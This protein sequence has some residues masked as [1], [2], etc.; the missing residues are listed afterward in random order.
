MGTYVN[1][2]NSGFAEINDPDYVDK[3][4][5]IRLVNQTIGK[6]NKLTCISRPR[7]FG[8]SYAARMLT[9]YYDCSCDSHELFD[10]KEIAQD[11]NYEKYLNRYNVIYLEMTSFIS[12]ARR[13]GISLREVPNRI[14]AA[15]KKDLDS[16][17]SYERK[18]DSL[19]DSLIHIAEK[20][21]G[22]KFIFI[23]DE[24]DAMIREAKDDGVAQKRYLDL[25][26]EWFKN[27][28]F[29]PKA[30]AAA[31]MTGIL[32]IKKDGSQSAISEFKEYTMIR[33]GVF[34]PYIGFTEFEVL[35]LCNAHDIHFE[36]MKTWYDGYHFK[37]VSSI[38]NPNSIMEAIRNR[39]FDSYWVQTSAAESLLTYIDMNEDGLQEDVARLISG[40]EIE[41]RTEM[42]QNDFQ[43]FRDKDDVLTLMIHLGYLTYWKDDEG[44]GWVRIPNEEVRREFNR[45]LRKGKHHELI[46]LVRES[47]ELLQET[48][49][50]NA[51]AVA[52]AIAK[53]H[54]SNYA[55]QYYNNEQSLRS[56]IRMAYL[57]CVDQYMKIEELPSGHGVADL[58]FL[59]KRRS[60]L[61]AL[62]MELKW[63]QTEHAAIAQIKDRHYP[64]ILEKFC[65]EILLVGINYDAKTKEHTCRIE[66][67]E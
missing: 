34:A 19:T 27:S 45:M 26:R 21:D 61:P 2:G 8:K 50:G 20:P 56:T 12:S 17:F 38:Y 32:P 41:V 62:V 49:E 60:M 15:I 13:Q 22:K 4:G 16:V 28:T 7:R 51:E 18:D 23:I 43:T 25:L 44:T 48:I 64:A 40:E 58:V 10:D 30:V 3:T 39:E 67:L 46:R 37:G 33:P 5:M 59:P 53:V 29:T 35:D 11:K 36:K 1:P 9:A 24:W 42:F 57:S 66:R 55:P 54:D 52:A 14:A 6:K 47:D 31:Y 65:G 63:N